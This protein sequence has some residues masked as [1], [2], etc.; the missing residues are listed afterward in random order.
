M[1]IVIFNGSRLKAFP[2][3]S[4]PRQGYPLSAFQLNTVFEVHSEQ[5][6]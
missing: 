1:E 3:I 2:L 5:L 6:G 4:G